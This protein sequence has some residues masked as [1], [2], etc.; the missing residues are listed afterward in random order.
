MNALLRPL[1]FLGTLIVF[2]LSCTALL[3]VG[4]AALLL[5]LPD[6]GQL[7][8]CMTT[9]MYHVRL[10]PGSENYVRLKDISPHVLHAVIAAEDGSFYT[11]K[12]FDWHE[13]RE[14]MNA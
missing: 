13:I 6:V 8:K 3:G 9:S 11:H 2:L 7:E 12:G 14:S 4:A 10:C 5:T 1:R